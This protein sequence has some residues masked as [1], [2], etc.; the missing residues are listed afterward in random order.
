MPFFGQ[1]RSNFL[2]HIILCYSA[3]KLGLVGLSNTLAIEGE[4][5]GIKTNVI[6]PMATS[7]LTED[8]FPPGNF[9]SVPLFLP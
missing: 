7:R 2:L 6:L 1:F 8:I 9:K 4:R 5:A 3:A